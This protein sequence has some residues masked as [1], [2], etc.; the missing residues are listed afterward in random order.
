MS[1]RIHPAWWIAGV[2]FLTIIGAA[3]FRSTPG[4]LM[5]PLH[6]E[7]G[8]PHGVIGA[9][10]SVNLLLF[11]LTA[12]FSA[13]LMER[14]GVRRVVTGALLLVSVGSLLPV[15][16]T[17]SWQLILCWG[18]LVGLGTGSMSMAMVA[19]IT[20]RWF[21][22][23][24]GLVS[25]ILTAAGATGQ[26]IFLPVLA[27]LADAKGWRWAAVLTAGVALLVVPL[28]LWRMRDHPGAMGTTAYGAPAGTP[29]AAPPAPT[30]GIAT[31]ALRTLRDAAKEPIFWLL[32]ATFAVCGASTNGLVGTHFIPAAHDH[33]MAAPAAA[34]LLALIGIFD[35]VGTIFSGWLTDRMSSGA[36]L[37]AYYGL[38]GLSLFLLPTLFAANVH[39]SMFVFILFYGLDW[40][41]TV[42][43]TMALCRQ[44]FGDRAPI[45]FGW[46]FASHQIGAAIAAVLAGVVR[47]RLGN[48]DLAWYVSGALCLLAAGLCLLMVGG[49]Q[50]PSTAE[51]RDEVADAVTQ[52]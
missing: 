5:D 32:A 35:V 4:V 41:A 31:L 29:V 39:P 3:G 12:P 17:H 6:E 33:G 24:R 28:V 7:F 21:V 40:V 13:A 18:V 20:S 2:T 19:T 46:V 50:Q 38:R 10:V 45:V 27:H 52:V 34:S 37:A 22:A 30:T 16:M 11:G 26:L 23:R 48:Y 42:P 49:R 43:P 25:G 44:F 51:D 1:R 9:A 47:D 14:F 36:L 8:W 15:W